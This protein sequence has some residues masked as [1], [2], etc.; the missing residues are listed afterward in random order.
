MIIDNASSL[1]DH[2]H[3]LP[4]G[5]SLHADAAD[6]AP[7]GGPWDDRCADILHWSAGHRP[8]LQPGRAPAIENGRTAADQS[9]D[10][11]PESRLA[12]AP[13]ATPPASRGSRA[14]THGPER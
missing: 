1:P 5:A 13:G 12:G 14:R 3:R 11:G 4:P 8:A 6:A 7:R 2:D 9:A 10:P